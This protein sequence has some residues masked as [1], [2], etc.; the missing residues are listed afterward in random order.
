MSGGPGND[1]VNGRDGIGTFRQRRDF[2]GLTGHRG[3]AV[4]TA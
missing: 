4:L 2:A 1:A 3:M